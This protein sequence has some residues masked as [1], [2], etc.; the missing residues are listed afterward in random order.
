MPIVLAY[1]KK[2]KGDTVEEP[3]HLDW[4]E[5]NYGEIEESLED[6]NAFRSRLA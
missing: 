4:Y 6:G 1:F 5:D 3:G 2:S